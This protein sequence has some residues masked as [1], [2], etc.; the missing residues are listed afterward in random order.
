M[1]VSSNT[2][3]TGLL[4]G[5]SL[6][7]GQ[8]MAN[9]ASQPVP[10]AKER[11][12]IALSS[13]LPPMDGRHLK[14]ILVEVHYG[15]GESSPAHSHPCA[16]LGYVAAGSLRTQLQGEPEK[17]YHAGDSFYEPPN[18][19]HLVSA[20]ASSTEPAELIAYMICDHDAPL[21]VN[22]HEPAQQKGAPR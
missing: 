19:V 2:L 7:A 1:I 22:L 11:G 9:Q 4:M 17:T 8:T 10:V 15:P 16:V 12:R 13:E 18:G 21:S 6:L 5:C 20:N 14:A 3:I